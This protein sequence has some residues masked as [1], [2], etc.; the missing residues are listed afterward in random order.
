[1]AELPPLDEGIF[2]GK[3]DPMLTCSFASATVKAKH[4]ANVLE[5]VMQ[6]ELQVPCTEPVMAG[7]IKVSL[8]NW[9]QTNKNDLVR[10]LDF[11]YKNGLSLAQRSFAAGSGGS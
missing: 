3:C 5:C 4:H 6:D 7:S 2:G 11:K 10:T 9:N 8:Y 1:V